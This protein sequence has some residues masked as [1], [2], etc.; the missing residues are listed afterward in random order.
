[1]LE[2][3]QEEDDLLKNSVF[4][5]QIKEEDYQKFLGISHKKS[6]LKDEYLLK[7]G[8][9]NEFLYIILKG[10]VDLLKD[11]S[12]KK[13]TKYLIETLSLG[14]TIGEMRLTHTRFCS[15]NAIAKE[16]TETICTPISQLHNPDHYPCYLSLLK[17]TNRVLSE[18]LSSD[19]E[20][21]TYKVSLRD[22]R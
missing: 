2:L 14:Q 11:D 21:L 7:E 10:S 22:V 18:Q 6:F 19:N 1:M 9:I 8:E 16:F 4:L 17:S 12:R 20:K 5:T 15:L 13:E 3:T